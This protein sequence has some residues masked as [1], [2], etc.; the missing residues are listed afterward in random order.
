MADSKR[1]EALKRLFSLM[2]SLSGIEVKRNAPLPTKVPQGGMLILR[3]GEPGEP[4]PLLSPVRYIYQHQAEIEVFVQ[5][6][7]QIQR[8]AKLD[9]ILQSIG[10]AIEQNTTLNGVVDYARAGA[11]ELM[12]EAAEG[13]PTLKAALVPVILEYVTSN[14]LT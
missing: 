13:A 4:E 5:E 14:P 6:A 12:E 10:T 7:D 9:N 2:E 3:D 11:P 1:E 8:D